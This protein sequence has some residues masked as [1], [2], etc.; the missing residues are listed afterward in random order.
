MGLWKIANAFFD[1]RSTINTNLSK[2]KNKT[3]SLNI[4]STLMLAD[5]QP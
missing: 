1:C 4:R 3:N 2:Q 5:K